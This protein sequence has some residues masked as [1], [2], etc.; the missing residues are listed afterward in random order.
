[1]P[2]RVYEIAKD[3]KLES[4]VVLAVAR[5][6]GIAGAKVPS[7]NLDKI[8]GEYLREQ[9]IEWKSKQLTAYPSAAGDPPLINPVLPQVVQPARVVPEVRIA[10]QQV[11]APP[12]PAPP[13]QP[14]RPAAG[15]IPSPSERPNSPSPTPA[16]VRPQK[17]PA[18]TASTQ[19]APRKG[20]TEPSY[21][22]FERTIRRIL[23]E[24][25]PN[26]TLSNVL[27]FRSD[28]ARFSADPSGSTGRPDY[29]Y[30]VDHL[31]HRSSSTQD[32][33]IVIECKNQRILV[34]TEDVWLAEYTNGPK[35]VLPQL[36]RQAETLR[37]YVN[38]LSR[39]R[40]LTIN[41]ILVSSD[42]ETPRAHR[43]G[44]L[45]VSF[46]LC[47]T[48]DLAAVLEKLTPPPLRVAQSDILNLFRL[49]MP[50]P[51]LGHPELNNA[52]AYIE[53]CR[54]NIDVEL[55]RA[56]SPTSERWAI[57][58]S[59][60]MGKSVLLAYS[61]FV[62]ST[63]LRVVMQDSR[64]ELAEFSEQASLM[65]LPPHGQRRVYAFALKQKQRHVLSALYRRFVDEFAPLS[66]EADLGLRRPEIR[67]WDGKIPPDCHVLVI[68]EAHDLSASHAATVAAWINTPRM[69]RYLLIACDR[70]QKL[71]LVGR[72]EAIIEGVN[73]SRRTKKLRLN[74][75]NPFAVYAASLGLMFRWFAPAGPKVLPAKDDLES[76]FGLTVEEPHGQG[77]VSL[78]MRN[79]AHPANTWSHCVELFSH[80]EGALARLRPFRFKPQDVLWVRFADE[81]EHFDYEQL[82]CFTY[83]NL[84]CAESIELTDKYIKGQDFPIVVIEGASED[85]NQ[86]GDPAAEQRM[87]QRRK[88]LYICASRATAFLFLV[89]NG[90]ESEQEFAEIVRQLSAPEKDDDGFPRAWRFRVTQPGGAEKRRMDVFTDA[91]EQ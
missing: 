12:Q 52:L 5:Q 74:Y 22:R 11:T 42:S 76:G 75:R 53:R 91:N 71:R 37:C 58:G 78:S 9:L 61:L 21:A 46:F 6:L 7:S 59:A 65:G 85:M 70:H 86:W 33:L 28:Q 39:G 30:E 48:N 55:F 34:E 45:G 14:A 1:M 2:I 49:G 47:S 8:T 83:H 3:L 50:T 19:A 79:D 88:E 17:S 23:D 69:Q 64:K 87:W 15:V 62:F 27:L 38:P 26:C 63:N 43:S 44:Q 57:N 66:Q 35:D 81:D 56:F 25:F 90:R 13:Q 18:T 77:P 32:N 40:E 51:E 36:R 68:D 29:A 31:L 73:F 54:R 16:I 24:R 10:H 72:D 20:F 82:S 80:P 89:G 41:V 4:R 84:N 60:G 67:L